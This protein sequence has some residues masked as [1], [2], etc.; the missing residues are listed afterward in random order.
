MGPSSSCNRILTSQILQRSYKSNHNSCESKSGMVVSLPKGGVEPHST[1]T[2]FRF[3]VH[4]IHWALEG[5]TEVPPEAKH[6]SNQ[7]SQH[8]DWLKV[9]ELPLPNRKECLWPKLIMA[10]IY[11]YRHNCL[12]GLVGKS[13]PFNK[14]IA[15]APPLRSM[16]SPDTGFQPGLHYLKCRTIPMKQDTYYTKELLAT[17]IIELPWLYQWACLDCPI[18]SP[19]HRVHRWVWSWMTALPGCLHTQ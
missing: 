2:F 5:D 3:I 16:I 7:Y 9:S 17:F 13:F 18:N 8:F 19:V 4:S 14:A 15:V 6:T 10:L 1:P 11:I 12:D